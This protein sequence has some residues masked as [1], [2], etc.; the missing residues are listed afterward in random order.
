MST[1]SATLQLDNATVKGIKNAS[2]GCEFLGIRYAFANPFSDPT[3]LELHGIVDATQ[4]GPICHQ[5]P[6][7][8]EQTL[9]LDASSMSHD[10]LS[11]NV[12]V[13]SE[14][15]KDSN[16]PVLFWI[17]GGA[18]TNGA[19]S[20]AWYHGAQL[21]KRGCIVVTINY[22]L[23]IFGFLGTG[24]HGV[25][26][27]V[28]ALRWTNK[29]IADFGGNP[30]NVTILGESAGGSAV[31]T[32]LVT[33]SAEK[34]FHKAWAMSPSIGQLRTKS[35]AEEIQDT[36]VE[37][38]P[39]DT[40]EKLQLLSHQQLLEIQNSVL[41]RTS[42]EYDWF[43]PTDGTDFIP[44]SLLQNAAKCSKPF[45]IGTNR[46]ENKLWAAFDPRASAVTSEEWA[47]HVRKIFGDKSE[48]A[49]VIYEEL[50]PGESPHNLISAVNTDTAFRSRAW[51]LIDA[52][53]T[54]GSPSWMYWFTWPT[55]AFGG[56]LG[57]CHAL[58]IPFAFDNLDAPGG[59][60]F[61]G[62]GPERHPL[63]RR[64]ADEI[65]QFATHG[66]PSWAQYNLETRETL[67][68][69]TEVSLLT[70]P[71]GSIRKLFTL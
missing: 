21:A 17:H 36:L 62:E 66:H 11:L 3:D 70:D 37:L 24:N 64:F 8:L 23:G 50:R 57:S 16:L 69:D 59:E 13:P 20:L 43:S 31:V 61:T 1:I 26:D 5:T 44:S 15:T 7:F 29:Y 18:Y 30:N 38:S 25:K 54:S 19:G 35:R 68:L 28:S 33:P 32:L 12:F 22:R 52:R 65:S 39:V 53:V 6:G 47:A 34:L 10:C 14:T 41:T 58:D 67:R 40:L 55:P 9:G 2:G 71:E 27:M 63:A 46:D 56:I 60:M 4:N 49:R 42:K 45:V 51:G 48:Q